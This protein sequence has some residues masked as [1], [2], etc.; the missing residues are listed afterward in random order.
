MIRIAVP[1]MKQPMM[2][3]NITTKRTWSAGTD[4]MTFKRW[5]ASDWNCARVSR[6]ANTVEAARMIITIEVVSAALMTAWR[7]LKNVNPP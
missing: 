7:N 5:M 6:L 2:S 1:S 4:V 3:R